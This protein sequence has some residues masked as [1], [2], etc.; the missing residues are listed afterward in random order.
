LGKILKKV[1]EMKLPILSSGLVYKCR[2][3]IMLSDEDQVAKML[4]LVDE[5]ES[6]DDVINIFAGFDYA[7]KA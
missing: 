1:R 4:D 3:P 7:Q 5:L 6:N 2:M